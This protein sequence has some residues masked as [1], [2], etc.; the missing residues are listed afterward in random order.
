MSS[1]LPFLRRPCGRLHAGAVLGLLLA[2][3]HTGSAHAGD[4]D[5]SLL[6]L[7]QP[8]ARELSGGALS[9]CGWVNRDASGRVTGVTLDAEAQSRFRSLMSELGMVMAPSVVSP[10]DT[11]GFAGFQI[12]VELG[13]SRINNQ[14]D[15]WDGVKGVAPQS[16]LT[17]RPE[18]WLTTVGMFVRKGIWLPLPS[19]EVG[20]GFMHLLQ[21]QMIAYQAYAKL[22]LLEGFQG[23]PL[24]SLAAR[25][26][27]SH[28]TG[29]DQVRLDVAA[30]DLLASKAIGVGGTF[31]FEPF[32]GWSYVIIKARSGIIDAT[33]GC[34]GFLTS[35][36]TPGGAF[37]GPNLPDNDL[38]ANFQFSDQNA[39]LRQRFFG[40][41]KLKFSAVFAAAQYEYIPA[42]RSRD[43]SSGGG[44]RDSSGSQARVSVSGGF[45]F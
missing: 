38:D 37:C 14:A 1:R 30:F 2:A 10:A 32:G 22:A 29:T 19:M 13:L 36:G 20:A 35:G 5:L 23:W 39:I 40:G 24:P 16:R 9:E 26:A 31:R 12:S 11:I 6:N 45:D 34:D 17:S 33:P 28:L 18:T 4:N 7:C 44:A 3:W 25:A 42:G 43:D 27:L 21:S 15:H 41:A 8:V